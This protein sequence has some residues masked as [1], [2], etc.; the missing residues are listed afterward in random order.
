MEFAHRT[1]LHASI[2]EVVRREFLSDVGRRSVFRIWRY[3]P[4]AGCRPHYD[5]GLCTALLRASAPG[6]EVNLQGKLPSRPGRPGDY[7]YDEMG[8]ESL[9][10]ALPGWQAPTP[11]AAGDDTLVLCSNMAGVLSNGALSPVL[12]RVRS[13]WAQGGEKVRY[14]LVVELRPSQPRRWYSMN[15]GVE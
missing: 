7:R 9:I 10:D 5:P 15:Q 8:V 6:L 1:L 4:G 2:P 14:S 11:L 3:S 13:D 12:H